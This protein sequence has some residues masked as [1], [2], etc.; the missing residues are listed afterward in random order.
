M[1]TRA[2]ILLL[3][4]LLES[5]AARYSRDAIAGFHGDKGERLIEA[6]LLKAVGA[7]YLRCGDD[8]QGQPVEIVHDAGRDRYGYHDPE[9]GWVTVEDDDHRLYRADIA[10]MFRH[11]MPELM[12]TM[13]AVEADLAWN[14]GRTWLVKKAPSSIWFARRLD[15]PVVAQRLQA[16]LLRMPSPTVRVVLTSTDSE[17]MGSRIWPGVRV[18]CLPDVLNDNGGIDLNVLKMRFSNRPAPQLGDAVHL[19]DDGRVL[20]L[21]GDVEI[22]LNGPAQIAAVRDLVGA[23]RAGRSVIA[24]EVLSRIGCT[25]RTFAQL[26]GSKWSQ[27]APFMANEKGTWRLDP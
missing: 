25:A 26:F 24:S 19:S 17:A 27:I 3:L 13:A 12:G 15:D 21:N 6:G 7:P 9:R 14:L 23:Y 16:A 11:I 18:I 8:E 4:K 20:T 10:A 22:R 5:K 2:S 1:I